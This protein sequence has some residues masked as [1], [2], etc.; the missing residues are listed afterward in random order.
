MWSVTYTTE[1]GMHCSMHRNCHSDSIFL[2][3]CFVSLYLPVYVHVVPHQVLPSLSQSL[4]S[5][6]PCYNT[7]G[8]D[9]K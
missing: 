7:N 8:R 3:G 1:E 4:S 5:T 2:Y 9:S 6:F